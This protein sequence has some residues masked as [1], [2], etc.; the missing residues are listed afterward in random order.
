MS[1]AADGD[2]AHLSARLPRRGIAV[3][4]LFDTFKDWKTVKK[5]V[6]CGM[7]WAGLWIFLWSLIPVAGIVF[8]IIRTYEYRLTP[9]ILAEPD[10][11]I[12]EAIKV[13]RENARRLQG[14]DVRRGRS[15]CRRYRRGGDPACAGRSRI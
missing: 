3:T 1:I 5:R 10:M 9:Y 8:G 12:T 7:G 4:Q 2:D 15:L 14:Q 13:G 11:P 6:L